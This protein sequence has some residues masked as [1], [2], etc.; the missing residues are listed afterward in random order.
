MTPARRTAR[1]CRALAFISAASAGYS[2]T[3]HPY[4]V[5]PG[6]VAAAILLTVAATYD[7]EDQRQQAR[8]AA[9][10]AAA[11]ADAQP[12]DP[13]TTDTTRSRTA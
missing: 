4:L 13:G 6:M 2:A 10:K 12:L 9:L 8:H 5:I 7:T 3:H 1:A 11:D